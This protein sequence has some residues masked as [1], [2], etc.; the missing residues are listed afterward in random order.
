MIRYSNAEAITVP[1]FRD[2]L[3]RSTLAARRPI[4]DESALAAMLE[5]A[6]LLATAWDGPL[7]VGVGR[8]LTDFTFCCYL[9]DL[10]VDENYQ[11]QGIGKALVATVRERLQPAC[12]IILIAA[13][14]ATE[15]YPKIGFTSHPSAWIA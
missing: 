9:S 14:A 1:Q 3:V 12:K 4:N 8:A 15:Y 10:A 5:H 13:P 7:L 11:H 2:L 6:N